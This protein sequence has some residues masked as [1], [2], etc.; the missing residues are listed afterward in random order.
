VLSFQKIWWYIGRRDKRR[1]I[2]RETITL[3]NKISY[4]AMQILI[5]EKL[6]VKNMKEP[7]SKRK[8]KIVYTHFESNRSKH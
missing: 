3:K 2:S 1:K 5:K 8:V 6:K 4:N 7:A